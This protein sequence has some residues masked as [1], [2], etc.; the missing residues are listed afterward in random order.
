[1]GKLIDLTE[2]RFGKLLV[3]KKVK[4][5]NKNKSAKWLCKCDCGNEVE[6]LSYSLL[7]FHTRS[8]GCLRK[9]TCSLKSLDLC[10]KKFGRLTV[11]EKL[12]KRN[13][14]K[15]VVWKCLC[16]CGNIS[17]Q[18]TCHLR[19]GDVTSC[20]CYA[21]EQTSKRFRKS[22]G[23]A[24]FNSLYG[25]Y[26]S[27]AQKR[28]LSFELSL[29]EFKKLVDGNCY[30]CG[31]IPK[32]KHNIK[33]NRYGYYVYNGIDRVDNSK[34]YIAHNCVSCCFVCNHS[35]KARNK[36]E[37]YDWIDRVYNNIHKKESNE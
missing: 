11:V 12:S 33:S 10:G 24:S 22:Y 8:C 29:E 20:G 7:N 30:Y 4:N 2:K 23:E 3:I 31:D 35:K 34:G 5:T 18:V 32:K 13:K 6:V 25:S 28:S 21:S 37:F 27:S 17:Y 14:F 15:Q 19:S 16:D 36:Q 1:M 9:E 26:K